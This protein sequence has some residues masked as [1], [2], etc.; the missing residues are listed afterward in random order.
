MNNMSWYR[1]IA[2]STKFS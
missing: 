2:F 1:W